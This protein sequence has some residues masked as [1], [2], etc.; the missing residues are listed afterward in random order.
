MSLELPPSELLGCPQATWC[1]VSFCRAVF[2]GRLLRPSW[3]HTLT[4]TL[5]FCLA[6]KLPRQGLQGRLGFSDA[7]RSKR[8]QNKTKEDRSEQGGGTSEAFHLI[9]YR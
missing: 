3:A 6:S 7:H 8:E 2:P 9:S 1:A 4:P 5:K